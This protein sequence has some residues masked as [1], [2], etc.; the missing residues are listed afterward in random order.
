MRPTRLAPAA[1]F[2]LFMAG[3]VALGGW[4]LPASTEAELAPPPDSQA[5]SAQPPAAEA[6]EPDSGQRL[7]AEAKSAYQFAEWPGKEGLLR[8][9][10]N[11]G[12]VLADYIPDLQLAWVHRPADE[13]SGMPVDVVDVFWFNPDPDNNYEIRMWVG[14]SCDHA[15]EVLL[16]RLT[17]RQCRTIERRGSEIG[18]ELGDLSFPGSAAGS[19]GLTFVRNNVV[20][21]VTAPRGDAIEIAKIIDQA[22]L[23]RPTFS[24]YEAM[25]PFRP[26]IRDLHLAGHPRQPLYVEG[27]VGHAKRFP[28]SFEVVDP[29]GGQL[30]LFWE[31]SPGMSV[32][33]PE[34]KQPHTHE[35]SVEVVGP[36]SEIQHRELTLTAVNECGMFSRAT[37]PIDV[38]IFKKERD[39]PQFGED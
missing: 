37:L 29:E 15:H 6:P 13:K 14:L 30:F 19:K 18:V 27:Y 16:R 11:L 21:E 25:A 9:G 22:L 8:P 36:E 38:R 5:E 31:G 10:L 35:L 12:Q 39:I 26:Q 23:A 33:P 34:T 20:L 3:L 2:I 7:L 1:F 17:W 24:S 32:M 28:L 4:A